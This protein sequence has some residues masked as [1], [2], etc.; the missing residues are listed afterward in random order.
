MLATNRHHTTGKTCGELHTKASVKKMGTE[1]RVRHC[2]GSDGRPLNMIDGGFKYRVDSCQEPWY[3]IALP[4]GQD[5]G[6]AA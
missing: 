6:L 3:R 2:N 5:H 4:N 1:R